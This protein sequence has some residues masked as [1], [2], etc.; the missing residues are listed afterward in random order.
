MENKNGIKIF[1]VSAAHVYCVDNDIKLLDKEGNL[2]ESK[3]HKRKKMKAGEP[4]YNWKTAT[5]PESLFLDYMRDKLTIDERGFCKDFIKVD[6]NYSADVKNLD[7]INEGKKR[8]HHN[9]LRELY[10]EE[11]IYIKIPKSKKRVHYK[12]LYRTA[13]A[14]K[15]GSVIFI[16]SQLYKKA[17][18]YLTMGLIK[19]L[20][21]KNVDIVGLSAY[22]SLVTGAAIDYMHIPWENILVIEDETV[23]SDRGCWSVKVKNED[24]K[25][26]GI[27]YKQL[28]DEIRK[29]SHTFYKSKQKSNPDLQVISKSVEALKDFG[30][31]K[32]SLP[33]KEYT[34]TDRKCF[35][36]RSMT[37]HAKNVVWDGQGLIDESIFP[38]SMDGFVYCRNH[39]FKACLFRCNIQGYF[40]DKFK[41]KYETATVEDMFGNRIYVK[42]IKVITTN[43]AIKWLKFNK[44]MGNNPYRT[45]KNWLKKYNNKFAIIKTGHP[46]KYGDLQRTS[47]QMVNSLPTTD[48]E[49]ISQILSPSVEYINQLKTN[50]DAFVQHLKVTSSPYKINEVLIALNE[51]NEDFQYSKFFK[52]NRED[53][54]S[55]FKC[56]RVL[57]G[58]LLLPG[59]NLTLCGN[60]IA[61][62]MK[63]VGEKYKQEGCFEV[64][65]DAV[66]C[67][68]TR[69]T[70]GE[71]LAGFRNPHNAP[72]NIV[73]FENII[74]SSPTT[75][76]I[77]SSILFF[78]FC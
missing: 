43:N 20:P 31:E 52:D 6:F 58:K 48:E 29:S 66:Q 5:L 53:I 1:S 76:S 50:K 55:K 25:K 70:F 41:E 51:M 27:D 22:Q 37:D 54:I 34:Y 4:Y 42:D 15:E 24:Y 44:Y 16:R 19:N 39:F 77:S 26:L 60:P 46:S 78:C 36:D 2:F 32:D 62:L 3:K 69:F 59:D 61:L 14:A 18:S 23:M 35:V 7:G 17:H 38:E 21:A 67:Y 40:K 56:D 49:V 30:Y 9:K 47:Y 65:N 68:T 72:N 45:Y 33:K 13:G 57:E 64:K 73:C 74:K 11:G 63:A 75:K 12:M 28:E 71:K 10:Y 8:M